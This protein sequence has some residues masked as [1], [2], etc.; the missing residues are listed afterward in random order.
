MYASTSKS[1]LNC[2]TLAANYKSPMMRNSCLTFEYFPISV[3]IC[4]AHTPTTSPSVTPPPH[5]GAARQMY[6]S[7]SLRP[8][9]TKP[10]YGTNQKQQ[11][12]PM[13]PQPFPVPIRFQDMVFDKLPEG[14]PIVIPIPGIVSSRNR[15]GMYGGRTEYYGVRRQP[16]GGLLGGRHPLDLGFIPG[17]G[18]GTLHGVRK[19][20]IMNRIVPGPVDQYMR[21]PEEE[22]VIRER[23]Y[24]HGCG[25]DCP[26]GEFLCMES[27]LC[28]KDS[29]R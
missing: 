25:E 2:L 4:A 15:G 8:P 13:P 22:E 9:G 23:Q 18:Y 6:G 26:S 7:G 20:G 14:Y 29:L 24:D 17:R 28:I 11:K 1:T 3:A 27:C 19:Q 10:N 21:Q 5:R 16:T 12:I